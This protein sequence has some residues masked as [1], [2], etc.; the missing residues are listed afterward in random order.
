M[1][2]EVKMSKIHQIVR[3][4]IGK[5]K[6]DPDQDWGH[7]CNQGHLLEKNEKGIWDCP[8]CKSRMDKL[9]EE[10]AEKRR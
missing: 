7:R 9:N 3:D 10:W 2:D 4:M 5:N 1:G 8:L 6:Y